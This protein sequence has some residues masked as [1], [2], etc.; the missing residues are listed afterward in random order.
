M[1][2]RVSVGFWP[3]Q[4]LDKVDYDKWRK[5]IK[6]KETIQVRATHFKKGAFLSKIMKRDENSSGIEGHPPHLVF[7]LPICTSKKSPLQL[8][9]RPFITIIIFIPFFQNIYFLNVR[10]GRLEL[11]RQ[12]VG[13]TSIIFIIINNIINTITFTAIFEH[14]NPISEQ[15]RPGT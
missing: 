15:L 2:L 7:L 11:L 14:E 13:N 5:G 12:D 1:L 9:P 6:R 4:Y 3:R 8:I 10:R